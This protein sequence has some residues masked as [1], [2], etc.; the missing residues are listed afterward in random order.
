MCVFRER[1]TNMSSQHMPTPGEMTPKDYSTH[2]YSNAS[3]L[4]IEGQPTIINSI[5]CQKLN[6]VVCS[7]IRIQKSSQVTVLFERFLLN[8][9]DNST[10]H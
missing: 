8:A 1:V 6:N 4:M 3:N 10:T 5:F 9:T 7:V 2:R